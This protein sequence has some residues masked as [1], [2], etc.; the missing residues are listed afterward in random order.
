MQTTTLYHEL[1][2]VQDVVDLVSQTQSTVYSVLDLRAAYFQLP[3]TEESAIKTTFVTPHRGSF[4]FLRCPMGW[5]NSGYYCT[6]ALNTLFRHQI[7]TFMMVYVDDI[8][9]ATPDLDTH[10]TSL[11]IVFSKL[12]EA[13]LKLHPAKC[14]LMLPELKY[15]GFIFSDGNVRADPKK[16]AVIKNYP[17]PSCTKDVRS[18]VGLTNYFRKNC[19]SY[20][21][22][23]HGLVKLLRKDVPFSWGPE[24]QQSFEDLKNALTSPENMAI[25]RLDQP[26]ILTTDASDISVSFNLSQMIDGRERII[27]Y[28]ARGLRKAEL[29][30]STSEKELL[31]VVVG[32]QHYHDYLNG[33]KFIIRTDHLSLKYLNTTR[34]ATGRLARWNLI[35]GRYN[36]EIQ[37]TKGRENV[38]ADALSRIEL[39][40]SE[41][42]P[43][44]EP[45]QMLFNIEPDIFE[46]ESEAVTRRKPRHR[47]TEI[48]LLQDTST[49]SE[50][51]VDSTEGQIDDALGPSEQE[52]IESYNI[53][54]EQEKCPDCLPLI[55]YF[56]DGNLPVH[57]DALAR[58]IV[59]QSD[60]YT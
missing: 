6:Q 57:N 8:L 31:A 48:S 17:Q 60:Y 40:A 19:K 30:Y 10:L 21:D 53:S 13:N 22:K 37:H 15:L 43:E 49:P 44:E 42:G 32:V 47:L 9:L 16:T 52:L 56:R 45:D 2:C 50:S 51:A 55:A 20:A 4:K 59:I 25:P 5:S 54:D 38:V 39:P 36:F 24:Q 23:A 3:L 46:S 1:P 11:E 58:K 34:H 7:G 29:N 33:Q 26:L 12:R 27:E 28:G 35:L 41:T 18:F 14:S